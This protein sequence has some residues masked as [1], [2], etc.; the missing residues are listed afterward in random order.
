MYARCSDAGDM[1]TKSG[2]VASTGESPLS[3]N[4]PGREPL[5]PALVTSASASSVASAPSLES[6]L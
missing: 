3:T 6:C 1:V 5:R 2:Q 4:G